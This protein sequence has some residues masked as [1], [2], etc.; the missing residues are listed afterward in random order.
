MY[1]LISIFWWLVRRTLSLFV[2]IIMCVDKNVLD[3]LFMN[4]DYLSKDCLLPSSVYRLN[5][6]FPSFKHILNQLWNAQIYPLVEIPILLHRKKL[7]WTVYLFTS[8]GAWEY[9]CVCAH[10]KT[11]V[12]INSLDH[13]PPHLLRCIILLSLESLKSSYPAGSTNPVFV[14]QSLEIWVGSP[15][16]LWFLTM[17]LTFVQ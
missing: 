10:V 15:A 7:G 13:S 5:V 8:M 1:K 3:K 2:S 6:H 12:N 9:L 11:K 4:I 14:Y 16:S 17:L